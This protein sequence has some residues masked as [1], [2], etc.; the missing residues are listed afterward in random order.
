MKTQTISIT[1]IALFVFLCCSTSK[2]RSQSYKD[3]SANLFSHYSQSCAINKDIWGISLGIPILLLDTQNSIGYSNIP[4]N[5]R[6]VLNEN[7]IYLTELDSNLKTN[8][9]IQTWKDTTWIILHLP[10][11]GNTKE[12]IAFIAHEAFHLVQESLGISGSSRSLPYLSSIEGRY[13]MHIE[14]EEL[15]QALKSHN[16]SE[17]KNHVKNA[18]S[19]RAYKYQLFSKAEKMEKQAELNEGLA[20]YTG[21]LYANYSEKE[22]LEHYDSSLH[23]L[24][25]RNNE[26]A[27]PYLSGSL[28]ALL[29]DK[30]SNDWK[31]LVPE[32]SLSEISR[33]V[34]AIDSLIGIRYIKDPFLNDRLDFTKFETAQKNNKIQDSLKSYFAK[35]KLYLDLPNASIVFKSNIVVSVKG[36]GT[37]YN[38]VIIENDWGKLIVEKEGRALI[39]TERNKIILNAESLEI[40]DNLIKGEKWRLNIQDD[41]EVLQEGRNIKIEKL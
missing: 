25:K 39:S 23:K 34:F 10:F 28:Y 1:S 3:F 20:E 17:R 22:L 40:K 18:L 38:N 21:L 8:S 37:V 14:L 11:K 13:L 33:A 4:V 9:P 6:Q 7:K 12:A 31:E 16:F 29:N 26:V 15:K 32:K 30:V 41:W 19:I 24:E 2:I 5:A 27:Y 36:L 35:A